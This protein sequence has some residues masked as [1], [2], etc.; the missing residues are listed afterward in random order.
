[1]GGINYKIP[2]KAKPVVVY[3]IMDHLTPFEGWEK[4]KQRD[5][6]AGEPKYSIAS[7]E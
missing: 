5:L 4:L 3:K 1:M 6:E 7:T 2:L